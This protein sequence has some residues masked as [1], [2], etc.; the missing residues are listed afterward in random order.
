MSGASAL[1]LGNENFKGRVRRV[2]MVRKGEENHFL[3][4]EVYNDALADYLGLSRLTQ[5]DW[6][7]LAA[8]RAAPESARNPDM[9][10]PTP[11]LAK[12]APQ[13]QE[14]AAPQRPSDAEPSSFWD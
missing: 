1:Y 13:P 14:D 8:Q 7:N 5:D 11:L 3:D 10:S 4:C 12:A 9:F 2:W 6:A